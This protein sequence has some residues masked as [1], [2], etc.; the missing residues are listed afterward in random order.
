[1]TVNGLA[2][3]DTNAAVNTVPSNVVPVER[4]TIAYL[5]AGTT[6]QVLANINTSG[7]FYVPAN[8]FHLQVVRIGD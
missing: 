2:V 8:G 5:A 3:T 1:V 4:T 7:N 6:L